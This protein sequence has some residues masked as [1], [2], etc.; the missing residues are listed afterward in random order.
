M[1]TFVIII[2]ILI[3]LFAT[4]FGIFIGTKVDGNAT[5]NL[6]TEQREDSILDNQTGI[7]Y[8]IIFISIILLGGSFWINY[9]G[10]SFN[11]VRRDMETKKVLEVYGPSSYRSTYLIGV[12]SYIMIVSFVFKGLEKDPSTNDIRFKSIAFDFTFVL[13]LILSAS[14]YMF[15][16]CQKYIGKIG[17]KLSKS[18][19]INSLTLSETVKEDP[20][21]ITYG[22]TVA[23]CYVAIALINLGGSLNPLVF[24][25]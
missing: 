9:K 23:M 16:N 14:L 2:I 12:A 8:A 24:S 11:N 6:G 13:L 1:N 20:K 3:V 22:W 19:Y 7:V 10:H 15:F 17:T 25:K 4:T 18:P 21:C 5:G